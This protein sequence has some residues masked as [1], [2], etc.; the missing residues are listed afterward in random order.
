MTFQ[1]KKAMEAREVV[2][3]VT[4]QELRGYGIDIVCMRVEGKIG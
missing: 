3:E 1:S 4:I 2:H